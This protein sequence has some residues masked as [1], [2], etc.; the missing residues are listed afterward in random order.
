MDEIRVIIDLAEKFQKD[1]HMNEQQLRNLLLHTYAAEQI[2]MNENVIL[3]LLASF[4]EKLQSILRYRY[5]LFSN[6]KTAYVQN[7]EAFKL[8][9]QEGIISSADIFFDYT[10]IRHFM[11][12][13]WDIVGTRVRDEY[14]NSYLKLCDKTKKT[15]KQRVKGYIDVLHQMQHV[16]SAINPNR[17][18]RGATESNSKFLQR[19]RATVDGPDVSVELNH[20]LAS[21][22]Y[23]SL[24]KNFEKVLPW[25]NIVDN[26]QDMEEKQREITAYGDR[27]W[28]LQNF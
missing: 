7:Q 13:Q 17:I 25:V 8:A 10:K 11:R 12:H 15:N 9:E 2:S 6:E 28:F 24:N 1:P 27:S 19:A 18:I 23:R 16:I 14:V 3:E 5:R 22:K 4:A 26:F 21:D 20:P